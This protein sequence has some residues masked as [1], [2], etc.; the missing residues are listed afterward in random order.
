MNSPTRLELLID[1]IFDLNVGDML[2]AR[3][4]PDF[5]H[6]KTFKVVFGDYFFGHRYTTNAGGSRFFRHRTVANGKATVFPI[7]RAASLDLD[8]KVFGKERA[9]RSR[10]DRFVQ[11][12]E[13]RLHFR[14]CFMEG[15]AEGRG[16]FVSVFRGQLER[17]H[18]VTL[19]DALQQ[20]ERRS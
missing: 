7:R 19:T 18:R 17:H 12:P 1:L 14:P 13:L 3:K 2:T 6:R 20:V 15:K 11:R 9:T 16:M 4:R 5:L 10:Q 8:E